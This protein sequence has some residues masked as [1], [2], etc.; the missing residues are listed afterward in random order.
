MKHLQSQYGSHQEEIIRITKK[1]D[2][3]GTKKSQK[4]HGMFWLVELMY[5]QGGT[6]YIYK[7]VTN[8]SLTRYFLGYFFWDL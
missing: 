5:I 3:T 1:S 8:N 6:H 2:A 4:T 7:E